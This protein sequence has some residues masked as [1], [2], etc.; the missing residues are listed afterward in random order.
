LDDYNALKAAI[1]IQAL[2]IQPKKY[3]SRRN[4]FVKICEPKN[5]VI[6]RDRRHRA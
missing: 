2:S 3:S 5:R 4:E 6:A 1:S